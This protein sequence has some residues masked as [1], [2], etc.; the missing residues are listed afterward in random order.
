M[1][2][3][4]SKAPFVEVQLARTLYQQG[5]TPTEIADYLNQSINTVWDWLRYKTRVFA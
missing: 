1:K 3:H 2:H 5:A 4:R